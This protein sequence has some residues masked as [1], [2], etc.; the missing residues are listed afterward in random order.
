MKEISG[1]ILTNTQG[2]RGSGVVAASKRGSARGGPGCG[3]WGGDT[4]ALAR[5]GAVQARSEAVISTAAMAEAGILNSTP[6]PKILG[7]LQ[8]TAQGNQRVSG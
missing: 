3:C 2:S 4:A 7:N 5:G 1:T 8:P 6:N